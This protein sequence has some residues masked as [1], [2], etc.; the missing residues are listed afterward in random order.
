MKY[1]EAI[2]YVLNLKNSKEILSNKIILKSLLLD[3]V[4]DDFKSIKYVNILCNLAEDISVSKLTKKREKSALKKAISYLKNDYTD[5]EIYE[6]LWPFYGDNENQATEKSS[7]LQN[8]EVKSVECNIDESNVTNNCPNFIYAD[9][10]NELNENEKEKEIDESTLNETTLNDDTLIEEIDTINDNEEVLSFDELNEYISEKMGYFSL[11]INASDCDLSIVGGNEEAIFIDETSGIDVSCLLF[12]YNKESG[13]VTLRISEDENIENYGIDL[14]L[15]EDLIKTLT[16]LDCN[17]A[18]LTGNFSEISIE[19]TSDIDLTGNF[20]EMHVTNYNNL[21][22][23]GNG[24]T[25]YLDDGVY[26]DITGNIDDVYAKDVE[27]EIDY[28]GNMDIYYE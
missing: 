4:K 20:N 15:N 13:I 17:S 8:Y 27:Y 23:T 14:I 7:L 25:L 6:V 24:Y 12:S 2:R 5:K 1:S 3:L 21:D 11:I 18:D 19:N 28:V 16:I 9:I 26:T 10:P 22:I